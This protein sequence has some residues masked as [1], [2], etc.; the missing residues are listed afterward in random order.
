MNP[1]TTRST[2][3]KW[4]LLAAL[5]LAI[6]LG[7]ARA[8]NKRKLQSEAANAAAAAMQQAPVYQLAPQ[9]VTTVQ[10]LALS[11][12]VG[13]SGALKALQ[14]AAIKAKVAGELQGLQKREGESVSAGEVVARIDS[15][16][17]QARVRQAEQQAKSAQAQV[18][19][20]RRALENNQSLVKQG[21][22]S[23]TALETTS[24]NLAAAEAT[25]QAALAALDIAR[26][27][28]GDTTLRSPLTG[29]VSARLVQNG[30]RVALDARVLEVV[31]LSGFELEA[32]LAP[33]DA[34]AVA[35]GHKARLTVEGLAQPVDA[36]V[37]RI[38]P[39]VQ[40]GSRSV[41]VYLR[42]PAVAGMRQGLFAQG[43]IVT[44]QLN[45]PAVPL[46]AVRN[47]KPQPYIQTVTDGKIAHVPVVLGRQGLLDGEP[48]LVI[49]GVAL[50]PVGTTLL[51]VQAGLI[52][53]GTAVTLTGPTAAAT[54]PATSTVSH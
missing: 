21:F 28:L 43:Q 34:M 9:D 39:S 17:A 38:N 15:T 19:I 45:A 48:M 42:V 41:L 7:V 36:T 16:D 52:R 53:E 1:H 3:L 13:V 4:L 18:A 35:P 44:G 49:D 30:E 50:A 22:I 24:N 11:Q 2:W 37:A 26:K 27:A 25:H 6:G 20:S 51:R 33:A 54:A 46:S 40:A 5:V 29:Q 32:A 31:D 14:T 8:L 12:A 23:A 10:A 47:D